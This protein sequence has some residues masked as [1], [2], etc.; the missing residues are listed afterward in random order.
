MADIVLDPRVLDVGLTV[1]DT[2]ADGIYVCSSEPTNYSQ[3]TFG[4]SLALGHKFFTRGTVFGSAGAGSPDGRQVTSVAITDG[5]VTDSGT[6]S[7]WAAVD[8]T[9]TRLL[10][11]GVLTGGGAVTAGQAFTLGAI[12]IRMPAVA[13]GGA[14]TFTVTDVAQAWQAASDPITWT[15][16]AIG[17]AT[18]DRIVVVTVS[19]DAANDLS[20]VTV[21]GISATRAV[22]TTMTGFADGTQIWFASVPTGTTATIV[23]AAGSFINEIAIAV[24]IITGSATTAVSATQTVAIATIA[25]PHLITATVP[26]NGVALISV[27]VDRATTP[28]WT[29]ATGDANIQQVGG[30]SFCHLMAHGISST[31]SF[32]GADN[33]SL[34]MAMATFGP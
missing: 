20:S 30:N 31:P 10:A 19:G 6:V 4:G 29:N 28:S 33:F 14:L 32:T 21:G 5:V 22:G 26:T 34:T 18:S 11:R 2:E 17:T 3:A 16:V 15:G 13:G 8:S 1:L 27:L 25:D 9:N 12:T 23:V 7:H 24:G